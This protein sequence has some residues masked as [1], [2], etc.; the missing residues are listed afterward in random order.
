MKGKIIRLRALPGCMLL[1]FPDQEKVTESGLFIPENSQMRPEF[2]EIY[3][4]GEPMNAN[5]ERIAEVLRRCQILGQP[6]LIAF[7]LGVGYWKHN[8]DT[9]WAWLKSIKSYRITA[10]AAFME[11]VEDVEDEVAVA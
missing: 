2:A 10:P 1:R 5:E 6:V 8:Y 3:D 7:A 9:K 11:V 4:I